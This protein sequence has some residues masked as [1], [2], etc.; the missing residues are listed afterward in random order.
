MKHEVFEA[1]FSLMIRV[2]LVSLEDP[3]LKYFE[4]RNSLNTRKRS[5]AVYLVDP[6]KKA[7]GEEVIG[8]VQ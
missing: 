1:A 4:P 8:L 2:N 3:S 7:R 5:Y 6:V